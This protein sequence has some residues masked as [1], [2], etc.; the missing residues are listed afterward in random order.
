MNPLVRPYRVDVRDAEVD[1]LRSRL[2]RTRWPDAVEGARWEYGADLD[3]VRH[4]CHYWR[5]AYEWR[6]HEARLNGFAQ[7]MAAIDGCRIHFI[8][9]RGR[10][11][12]PIPLLITH[13]WPGSIVEM[14]D[15]VPML[16]DPA[17][18]G[19]DPADAFD[20][21]VP[22]IPGFGF[23]DRPAVGGMHTKR[24]GDIWADLMSLLGYQRFGAQG[25]DFGAAICTR[26]GMAHPDRLMGVHL[27]YIPGSY[28]PHLGRGSAPLTDAER[29][30]QQ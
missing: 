25:G 23:S 29:Q 30:F 19:G 24:V 12:R 13:G 26:L 3:Y 17:A 2:A 1:D 21:V 7:F 10:G 16:V 28:E 11:P 6:A 27:N 22:S 14:L 9:E 15:I 8:H 4:L 5:E 20:V 18:H